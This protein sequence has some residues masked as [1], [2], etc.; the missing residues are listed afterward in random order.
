[1]NIESEKQRGRYLVVALSDFKDHYCNR[2]G[3]PEDRFSRHL[4]LS[5]CR[6]YVRPFAAV[7]LL[8]SPKVFDGD[9]ELLEQLGK[10]ESNRDYASELG[11]LEYFNQYQLG[12]WRKLLGIRISV[13]KLGSHARLFR[14]R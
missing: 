1:M 5:S 13:G 6:F 3:I 11:S 8:L 14:H 2:F 4:L 9:L 10:T 12:I 7:L